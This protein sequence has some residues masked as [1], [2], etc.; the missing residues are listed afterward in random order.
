METTI[1]LSVGRAIFHLILGIILFIPSIFYLVSGII[2][3]I[4]MTD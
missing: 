4:L 2:R 1:D 3:L